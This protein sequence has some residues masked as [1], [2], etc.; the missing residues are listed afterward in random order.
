MALVAL[1]LGQRLKGLILQLVS[2]SPPS[3]LLHAAYSALTLLVEAG[4]VPRLAMRA[5]RAWRARFG[6][7]AGRAGYTRLPGEGAAQQGAGEGREEEDEDVRE[8][9]EAIQV[10]RKR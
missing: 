9:R 3:F 6:A 2:P 10:G 7:G 5:Q 4:T 8:E 1:S